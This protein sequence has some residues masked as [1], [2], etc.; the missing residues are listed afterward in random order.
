MNELSNSDSSK[1]DLIIYY[2][3]ETQPTQKISQRHH[4][5]IQLVQKHAKGKFKAFERHLKKDLK[6]YHQTVNKDTSIKYKK[7]F[8][9][10]TNYTT[11][12]ITNEFASQGF[13]VARTKKDNNWQMQK[14]PFL[15]FKNLD[16][17]LSSKLALAK[18]LSVTMKKF[19]PQDW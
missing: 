2:A 9:W 19:K 8:L 17:P 16:H 3:N 5:M 12:A 10:K 11:V 13:Y 4:A 7:G 14:L 15:G 18:F 1:K 6:T